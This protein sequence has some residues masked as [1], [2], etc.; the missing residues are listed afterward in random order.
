MHAPRAISPSSRNILRENFGDA[1]LGGGVAGYG[2]YQRTILDECKAHLTEYTQV[3][4]VRCL[5]WSELDESGAVSARRARSSLYS[6]GMLERATVPL[7]MPHGTAY[8]GHS[9]RLVTVNRISC[10]APVVDGGLHQLRRARDLWEHLEGLADAIWGLP[11]VDRPDFADG[12][13]AAHHA[14]NLRGIAWVRFGFEH[15][16]DA[17]LGVLVST[18][19]LARLHGGRPSRIE[20][21]PRRCG[22]DAVKLPRSSW[23]LEDYAEGL[24]PLE[25]D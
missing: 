1:L 3:D 20:G 10:T 25:D 23:L 12:P 15:Y 19:R 9:R 21:R 14:A 16:L 6:M 11:P 2:Y 8:K 5:D 17:L 22:A 4:F 24:L 7:E 18:G 13:R